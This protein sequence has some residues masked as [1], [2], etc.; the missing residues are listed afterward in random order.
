MKALLPVLLLSLAALAGLSGCSD[1]PAGPAVLQP[2]ASGAYVIHIQNQ[3]FVPSNAQ[4]PVGANVTWIN[5]DAGSHDV[6]AKDGSFGS[7][8]VAGMQKGATYTFHATAKGAFP[9][10]CKAHESQ[11]MTATLTVA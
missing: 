9:Y 11:G 1:T 2:D 3:H 10:V 7:G 5:D 6:H 4:V 8:G